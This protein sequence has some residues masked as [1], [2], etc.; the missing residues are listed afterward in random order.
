MISYE[1]RCHAVQ[2]TANGRHHLPFAICHVRYKLHI[3][4][5]CM[6]ITRAF[7]L[8]YFMILLI[9]INTFKILFLILYCFLV[10]MSVNLPI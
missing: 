1:I 2:Q 8:I 9:F 4:F 10:F 3:S 5:L 6:L 7:V